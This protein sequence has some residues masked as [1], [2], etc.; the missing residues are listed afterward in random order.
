MG[1][2]SCYIFRY[3]IFRIRFYPNPFE[4][5]WH[6]YVLYSVVVCGRVKEILRC[7]IYDVNA[8]VEKIEDAC[9][10]SIP[11][12]CFLMYFTTTKICF[13]LRPLRNCKKKAD[14]CAIGWDK[15]IH[16]RIPPR[17]NAILDW[18]TNYIFGG[19]SISGAVWARVW[20]TSAFRWA[21]NA[22]YEKVG[23]RETESYWKL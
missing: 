21:R 18:R 9:Q 11:G 14:R 2:S 10:D 6:L 17:S 5:L 22:A 7:F 15:Y 12:S 19:Q 23:S 4:K 20:I 1:S 13:T 8:C 3:V 16:L